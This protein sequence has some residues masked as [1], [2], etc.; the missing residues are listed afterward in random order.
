L[1]TRRLTPLLEEPRVV[2]HPRADTLTRLH[3]VHRIA[4][5]KFSDGPVLPLRLSDEV[6]QVIVRALRP[7]RIVGGCRRQRLDALAL[8]LA[9]NPHRVERERRPTAFLAETRPYFRKVRLQTT[10]T[11]RVQL[12]GHPS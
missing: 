8:M 6:Q 11:R 10:E 3:R 1:H 7:L 5:R 2:D 9:E 4:R 12:V